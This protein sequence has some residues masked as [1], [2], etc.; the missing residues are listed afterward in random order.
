MADEPLD[1]YLGLIS[2]DEDILEPIGAESDDVGSIIKSPSPEDIDLGNITG[3]SSDDGSII[4]SPGDIDLGNINGLIGDIGSIIPTDIT[5]A[6]GDLLGT[7]G[8]V[9]T[10]INTVAGVIGSTSAPTGRVDS[11]LASGSPGEASPNKK[12]NLDT[13]GVT[14]VEAGASTNKPVIADDFKQTIEPRDNM[15][16]LFNSYTYS[17]SIYLMGAEQYNSMVSFGV[18]SVK[19]LTLL[20]QSGGITNNI[21]D[22]NYGAV[23]SEFFDLDFYIDDVTLKGLVSGQSNSAS[24]NS[25]SLDFKIVEPNGFSFLDRLHGAVQ[26]HNIDNGISSERINYASQNYLMVIRFYGYDKNG[27]A[28]S[29]TDLS[30]QTSDI[31]TNISDSNAVSEKFIP[32]QF[33]GIKFAID[34]NTVEYK[35]S[36]V[37]PQSYIPSS[38]ARG[39]IPFN[40]Q[41]TG[42]T[43]EDLLTGE[44][45][46]APTEDDEDNL[47]SGEQYLTSGLFHALNTEQRLMVKENHQEVAD[48]YKIIFEDSTI[49]LSTVASGDF[50]QS[51]IP[52]SILAQDKLFN[53]RIS[54]L[55]NKKYYAFSAGVQIMAVLDTILKTSSYITDQ[56]QVIVDK[57]GNVVSN[58]KSQESTFQWYKI[59]QQFKVKEYDNIRNDYGYEITYIISRYQVNDVKSPHFARSIYRGSHKEY[60]YWFTGENTEVL[61][62]TQDYNYLYFQSFGTQTKYVS[63]QNNARDLIRR[64]RQAET[65]SIQGDRNQQSQIAVNAASILYSPSDQASAKLK[66][67]GDP[68]WIAQSEIF[69][70]PSVSL[71]NGLGAFMPD[72]SVNYDS[73][74]VLFAV[75]YNTNVDYNLLTGLA[76]INKDINDRE[77]LLGLNSNEGIGSGVP[78]TSRVSLIY[79]ANTIT[80]NF[81]KGAFDQTLEGTMMLFPTNVQLNKEKEDKAKI[82][83]S[84]NYDDGGIGYWGEDA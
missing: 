65:E 39:Q 46:Y 57:K 4:E 27:N 61:S 79:R 44:S 23:R 40:V 45:A 82:D 62:F 14:K 74:E 42:T 29:A 78:S 25:F 59:R 43:V 30:N 35:C 51:A 56:Q 47:I 3:L 9:T 10:S 19:D 24:H 66:I 31:D 1:D 17:I 49:R 21:K 7:I 32:F 63:M 34:N 77:R 55:T 80:S 67:T 48:E 69:Y 41:L 16:K 13:D 76:D 75:N 2:Q 81:S 15:F 22:A 33:S 37:T 84:V 50:E 11:S 64:Y 38:I 12:P 54:V 70:S 68:D 6:V 83:P 53:E 58:P 8:D 52:E 36:A 18:K 5:S 72:G 20:I 26:K 71:R 28:V 73:S 60:D